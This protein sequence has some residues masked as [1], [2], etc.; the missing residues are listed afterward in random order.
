MDKNYLY[1]MPESPVSLKEYR[2]RARRTGSVLGWS[3]AI[4][5]AVSLLAGFLLQLLPLLPD[6]FYL[7]GISL[8]SYAAALPAM[9]LFLH[10]VPEVR[11]EP[12]KMRIRKFLLFLVLAQGLG[13]MFNLMGNLFHFGFSTVTGRDM[14]NMNPV[15]ELIN[16]MDLL[17]IS[18]VCLFGPIIE[19]YI[20]RWAILNRL[21]PYGEKAA[22]LYTA[23]MFGLMHG[24]VA[25]FLYAS[26]IG[27]ILGYMAVKTGRMRYN[28][29]LHILINS[30]S[31]LLSL[32]LMFGGPLSILISFGSLI[33]M[34]GEMIAALILLAVFWKETRL[35]PGDWPEGIR[36]RDFSSALYLNCGT[37]VFT[38]MCLGLMGYYLFL[39]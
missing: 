21:R 35:L 29:L 4:M 26:V 9:L 15:N 6:W 34:F 32:V 8:L 28:C 23:L 36:Y 14:Y 12:K 38:L 17:T 20:F 2:A 5:T 22:V 27:I 25:Q 39:A 31:M 19:E 10:R 3:L 30:F 7:S 1:D 24:N 16:Q 13:T 11:T 18:Y 33:F 37:A